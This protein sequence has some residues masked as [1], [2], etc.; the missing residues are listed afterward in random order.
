MKKSK[1]LTTEQK[2]ELNNNFVYIDEYNNVKIGTISD[3][4]DDY[5]LSFDDSMDH[6]PIFE[7]GKR[8]ILK[9]TVE[10]TP[11]EKPKEGSSTG[12]PKKKKSKATTFVV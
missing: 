12:I 11:W 4:R 9:T 1:E 8:I 6:I 2:R 7:I 5:C 3:I 10:T